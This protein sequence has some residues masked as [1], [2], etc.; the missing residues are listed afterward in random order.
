MAAL[1]EYVI[2]DR[3]AEIA[4]ARSAAPE[5]ISHDAKVL[6]LGPHAESTVQWRSGTDRRIHDS[7]GWWSDGTADPVR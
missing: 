5:S 6:V 7:R 1:S 2:P 4:L 3:N